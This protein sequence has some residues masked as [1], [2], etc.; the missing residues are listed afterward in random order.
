MPKNLF[1]PCVVL[2]SLLLT[3]LTPQSSI[4]TD[5]QG[6][7]PAFQA[8][9]WVYTGGPLGGMG[10]DIRANP[11]DANIM[12]VTDA[13]TGIFR[14]QDGGRTWTA[15]NTGIEERGGAS[16]DVIAVFCTTIDPNNPN[17]VWLGL[18]INGGVYRS[19]DGG[20][21]WEAR[22]NGI[23]DRSGLIVRGIAVEPGNS[24]V[25]YMAGELSSWVWAGEPRWGREFDRTMG[26]VYKSENAG[27]QW[28]EIWRGDSL[29]R[30]VLIDPT[31]VDILYVSTGIFDR[32][33]AN[34]DPATNIAGGVG[35]LKSTDGGQTWT[36]INTGLENLFIGSL[37][38]HPENPQ[39][40]LAAAGNNAYPDGGGIYLTE[41]GGA[42]WEH[43]G[44]TYATAVEFAP[45]DPSIAYAANAGEF[46]RSDDSGH[47]WNQFD[48]QRAYGWGP[49]G[50][51]VGVPIDFQVDPTDPMHIF[52]NNYGGGNFVS[53][54]GGET[55]ENASIGYTGADLDG[56]AID[57]L[58]PSV[59][60]VNGRSGPFRSEDSGYSWLGIN[61]MMDDLPE[62]AEG[63]RV[64][65]DPTDPSHVLMSSAHWGWLYESNDGGDHWTLQG[66]Y[67]DPL[68]NLPYPD[69]NQKFQGAQAIVFAP[70]NPQRVYQGWGV[71]R[72]ATDVS[73]PMCQTET[74]LQVLV[75]DD[76][77]HT[78]HTPPAP[79]ETPQTRIISAEGTVNL[80]GGAGT[81]FPV[82]GTA[83][84]GE[85]FEVISEEPEWYEI[86]F[87]SESAWVY[88]PL[89]REGSDTG[90][91]LPP[92]SVLDVVVHPQDDNLLW[93]AM[94]GHGVFVSRDGGSSWRATGSALNGLAVFDLALDP[95]S[96]DTL[97]AATIGRGVFKSD[98]GGM[99]WR[100]SSSGMDPNENVAAVLVDPMRSEI[101][102]A[103]T[104]NSGVFVSEDGGA[105]WRTVNEGLTVRWGKGL[106]I[107]ADGSVVYLTTRG[108]GVFRLGGA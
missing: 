52:V 31:N 102:Y 5:A 64:A 45:S 17:I 14:S 33:A 88:A 60:F 91:T 100:A 22:T 44:S 53:F 83:N 105:R 41:N 1:I 73:E 13:F 25:V 11:Q 20:S 84:T 90:G 3:S 40:L 98:D 47:T 66:D 46:F 38:M 61:P 18:Q 101:V 82:V 28:R 104:W 107:S 7:V 93:A 32:E 6:G 77:G 96:P 55:W 58:N 71:W 9:G 75:S 2:L 23:Q 59:I 108:G 74:L 89:T 99:T 95:Q 80:R 72:C 87:G 42:S 12:F 37:A 69:T 8:G 50:I 97:Y 103:A 65:L 49:D 106:A 94:P 35:V 21:T 19:D 92:F 81:S 70:S 68:M 86:R 26:V 43:V 48:R 54:D 76:G 16:G 4:L 85:E 34:S 67:F 10:Y 27:Q 78:W 36:E 29:A 15:S 57:P 56:I 39:V 63:A 51:R 24:D 62:I 30:Y 79:A